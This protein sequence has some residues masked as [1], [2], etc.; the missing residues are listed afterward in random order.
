M[1]TKNFQDVYAIQIANSIQIKECKTAINYELLFSDSDELFYQIDKNQLVYIFK[2]GV[3]CFY[4]INTSLRNEVLST[5]KKSCKTSI[6]CNNTEEVVITKNATQELVNMDKI[7]LENFTLENIRLIML[8]ISQSVVLDYYATLTSEILE[9]TNK[10]TM[11]LEEKGKLNIGG[12]KLKKY[13]GKVLNIKNKISEH[14]YILDAHD[15]IW[16]DEKLNLLDQKLKKTYDLK[17]RQRS[18]QEQLAIIKENLDLFKDLMFHK[19]SSILEWIII[20]L[21]LVEVVDMFVLKI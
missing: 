4:N 6:E 7:E 10:H 15:S 20:I 2:Y 18:I 5:L 17:D 19:Q 13:I 1:D 8:N 9:D 12:T 21:I 14:L 16:G 3:V 11:V